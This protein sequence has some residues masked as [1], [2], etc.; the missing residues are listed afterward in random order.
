MLRNICDVKQVVAAA[1]FGVAIASTTWPRGA[2]AVEVHKCLE[3]LGTAYQTTPCNFGQREVAVLSI[4]SSGLAQMVS[5]SETGRTSAPADRTA[6][7]DDGPWLPLRR[8]TLV[9]GMLDDEVLNAPDGGV[10]GRISRTRDGRSWREVWF[11]QP[12][13]GRARV[14]QFVN[15]RLTG[16]IDA[17]APH[18]S[19]RPASLEP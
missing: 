14:L 2:A 9:A 6:L 12:R 13:E 17:D 7:G 4:P 3:Q 16:I 10:P 18:A 5:P 8:R 11:Y 15:G 19:P 1:A